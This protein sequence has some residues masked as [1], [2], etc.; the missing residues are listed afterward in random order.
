MRSFV[1]LKICEDCFRFYCSSDLSVAETVPK[2]L[3]VYII[4]AF[5]CLY[6]TN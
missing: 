1:N 6:V 4:I 5:E 2:M 3:S